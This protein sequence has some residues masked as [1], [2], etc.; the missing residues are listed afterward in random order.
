MTYEIIR[1]FSDG[2]NRRVKTVR[3]LEQAQEHCRDARTSSKTAPLRIKL[4]AA[5]RGH[6]EWFD[7]YREK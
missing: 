7:G 4:N 2:T 6:G 1:F 5:N 3:T